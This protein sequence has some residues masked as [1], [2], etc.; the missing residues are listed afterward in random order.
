MYAA[1]IMRLGK[2]KQIPADK[3]RSE[4][5]DLRQRLSFTIL[6]KVLELSWLEFNGFGEWGGG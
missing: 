3:I 5:R 6:L 1:G 2:F 4:L